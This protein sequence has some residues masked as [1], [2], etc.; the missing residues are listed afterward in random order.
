M[1]TR[2]GTGTAEV[3]ATPGV[4]AEPHAGPQT[5]PNSRKSVRQK[6]LSFPILPMRRAIAICSRA[7]TQRIT[8]AFRDPTRVIQCC[9]TVV[10]D[11][12]SPP[13]RCSRA[14]HR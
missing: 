10:A 2:A 13:G 6:E 12:P 8:L 14:A 4:Y 5:Q 11:G 7:A 9:G 3:D 1:V